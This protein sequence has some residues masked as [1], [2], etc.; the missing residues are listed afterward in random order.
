MFLAA[1]TGGND[2]TTLALAWA[3][4]SIR[5]VHSLVQATVNRIVVR[6]SLFVLGSLVLVAFTVHEAMRLL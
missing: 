6:F 4:V 5:I 2:G 1:L 3:Y